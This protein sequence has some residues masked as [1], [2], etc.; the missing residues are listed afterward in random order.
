M[1]RILVTGNA[2]SGKSTLTERLGRDLKMQAK[3]LDKIVWQPGWQKTPAEIKK[4]AIA[5]LVAPKSWLIDGVSSLALEKSDAVVFL[6]LPLHRSLYN[7]VMRFLKNGPGT[8]PG[9]PENCPEYIGVIKAIKVSF[10]F[11]KHMRPLLLAKIGSPN[12][13]YLRSHNE[14]NKKYPGIVKRLRQNAV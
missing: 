8:R 3:S 13:I 1:P 4:R 12:F 7:I 2:G 11:R 10:Y 5:K 6:D 9:L 14:L